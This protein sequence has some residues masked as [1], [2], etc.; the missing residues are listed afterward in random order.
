MND[1]K[2]IILG[3]AFNFV[4]LPENSPNSL[5]LKFVEKNPQLQNIINPVIDKWKNHYKTNIT[6]FDLQNSD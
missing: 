1:I 6:N 3:K 2:N 5:K 4:R